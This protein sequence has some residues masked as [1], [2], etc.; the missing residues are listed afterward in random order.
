M[1]Y[2][3]Y[4]LW[5]I[6]FII[7]IRLGLSL[8]YQWRYQDIIPSNPKKQRQLLTMYASPLILVLALSFGLQTQTQSQP[9]ITGLDTKHL[10]ADSYNMYAENAPAVRSSDEIEVKGYVLIE[11][12]GVEVKY[13]VITIRDESYLIKDPSA[14]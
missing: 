1:T 6:A 12:E 2:L 14:E 3:I 13:F 8:Y 10:P 9:Q 4:A 11:E 5:F 7:A